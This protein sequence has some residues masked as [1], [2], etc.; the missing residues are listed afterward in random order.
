MIFYQTF[1]ARPQIQTLCF[2]TKTRHQEQAS[3]KF[4]YAAKDLPS[5]L[6]D[7]H[8]DLRLTSGTLTCDHLG[9]VSIPESTQNTAQIE[10]NIQNLIAAQIFLFGTFGRGRVD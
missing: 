10:Q 9:K 5:A 2:S 4:F 8:S 3:V 1:G 7:L 6:A